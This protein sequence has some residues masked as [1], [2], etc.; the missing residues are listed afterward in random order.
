MKHKY[1]VLMWGLG[2]LILIVIL[3]FVL[4]LD[5]IMTKEIYKF[6]EGTDFCNE[7]DMNYT[8]Y[9]SGDKYCDNGEEL[10]E[11]KYADGFRFISKGKEL[12]KEAK[13]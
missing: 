9:L 2:I 3:I 13:E 11:I 6:D 4:S 5:G 10:F 7:R 8:V 1:Q 12:N